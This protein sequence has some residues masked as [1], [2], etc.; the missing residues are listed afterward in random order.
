LGIENEEKVSIEKLI[1]SVVSRGPHQISL[2]EKMMTDCNIQR[3]IDYYN[4][5]NERNNTINEV[6]T[7]KYFI[8]NGDIFD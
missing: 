5:Y 3:Y 6:S 8:D 2:L 7:L 1:E 4:E